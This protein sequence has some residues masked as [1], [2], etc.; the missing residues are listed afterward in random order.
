MAR[1]TAGGVFG[2][3]TGGFA[4]TGAGFAATGAGF[5][6]GVC[7]GCAAGV[8]WFGIPPKRAP[9]PAIWPVGCGPIPLS[10]CSNAL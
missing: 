5:A 7:A 9:K 10:L 2:G 3:T 4:A 8:G 6:V 1:A